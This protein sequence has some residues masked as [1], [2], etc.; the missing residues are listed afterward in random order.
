[1]IKN[2]VFDFG[3]ILLNLD[4]QKTFNNLAALFDWQ[5]NE[6]PDH[7][8]TILDQYEMGLF[9]E[10]SFL[11][12]LQKLTPEIV[13]ERQILDAWNSMLLS[14]PSYRIDYVRTL[15][16][17]YRVF[18]LSNTN[19]THLYYIQQHLLGAAGWSYFISSFDVCYFS[20]QLGLRKPDNQ[21]Y[22]TVTALSKLD[23][24]ETLFIDDNIHNIETAKSIGWHTLH[25]DPHQEIVEVLPIYLRTTDF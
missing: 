20:H 5:Q 15:R 7:V 19:H 24:S 8:T 13:T 11:Y 12:R 18:L 22:D 16:P 10:G 21:I 17:H 2:I 3:G 25:H 6:Y 9:S 4:Y 14:V 1:M 23:P